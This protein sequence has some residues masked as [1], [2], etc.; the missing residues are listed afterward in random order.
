MNHKI[1]T[2]PFDLMQYFYTEVH[3]PLIRAL[4]RLPGRLDPAALKRAVGL[5]AATVPQIRCRFSEK[6][7][8]WEE[9]AFS[10]ER[11]VRVTDAGGDAGVVAERLLLDSIDLCAEPHLK[12]HLVRGR[13]SDTLCVIFSHMVGDGAGF[14]QY[15]YLLA[16][17]YRRCVRTSGCIVPPEPRDRSVGQVLRGLDVRERVR[18]L[19]APVRFP[20]QEKDM[21]LPLEGGDGE[22]FTVLRRIG[23]DLLE[24]LQTK[25]RAGGATLNDALIAAYG[26]AHHALTH[27]RV[28]TVPC[29]VDLRKYLPKEQRGGI[30]N[31]TGS[32]FCRFRVADGEP[33]HE[34]LRK[35]AGE[36]SRQKK[37]RDCLKGPM[38]LSFL[39]TLLPFGAAKRV[40]RE[41]F[42]IPVVSYTNLGVLDRRRLDFGTGKPLD[43][44]L[45]TAV[46]HP[47][48]FQV[49]ASTCG[50][51]CT[52]GSNLCGTQ[53]DR[54]T[55]EDFLDAMVRALWLFA[56][57]RAHKAA[58]K[59]QTNAGG[60]SRA[61][62]QPAGQQKGP[63]K[64]GRRTDAADGGKSKPKPQRQK[65]V[66]KA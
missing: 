50:G 40:F 10:A 47:P 42:S 38:L 13:E 11:V 30:C 48:Y 37:S 24:R 1:K 20:K 51:V 4:I 46:K 2:E 54:R 35:V 64:E 8:G 39:F 34:T 29:P 28:C 9:C 55:A 59:S 53:R 52:L 27:S 66:R 17:L 36:L 56:G 25:A 62:G 65:A 12:I 3:R 21:L 19:H 63:E 61:E 16:A 41:K 15:L 49:S 31:L 18:I 57:E 58:A 33:F 26:R 32:Y 22:P 5:S 6:T 45:T 60:G 7:H 43:A 44:Y 14:R 23:P